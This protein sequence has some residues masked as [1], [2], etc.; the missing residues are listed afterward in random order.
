M[1]F[2]SSIKSLC[3]L[4]LARP[5]R[6]WRLPAGVSCSQSK[7]RLTL[8][9]LTRSV[10][11]GGLLIIGDRLDAAT[12]WSTSFDANNICFG[13]TNDCAWFASAQSLFTTGTLTNS[14]STVA[15]Q[16]AVISNGYYVLINLRPLPPVASATEIS[17][18]SVVL[19][20]TYPGVG[21][22]LNFAAYREKSTSPKCLSIMLVQDNSVSIEGTRYVSATG[23][24]SYSFPLQPVLAT[25]NVQVMIC[26]LDCVGS[27]T[28][29]GWRLDNLRMEH[30]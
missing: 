21:L 18:T 5:A 7:S 16:S 23:W 27:D 29:G 17:S 9:R 13:S 10:V 14:F 4:P 25:N 8:T 11:F 24:K 26:W 1:N 28:N 22:V 20:A 15:T 2:L 12:L 3:D 19:T 30:P 6:C